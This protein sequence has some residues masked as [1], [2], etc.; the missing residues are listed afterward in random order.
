MTSHR[1]GLTLATSFLLL[2]QDLFSDEL[3]K[4]DDILGYIRQNL[5]AQENILAAVTEA[6]IKYTRIR[7][8]VN[9]RLEK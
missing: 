8:S 9:E 6:N 2:L 3:K 5:N 4:H 1:N 7:R